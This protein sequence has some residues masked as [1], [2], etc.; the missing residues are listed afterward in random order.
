[1]RVPIG[2]Y[3]RKSSPL[4][5]SIQEYLLCSER[6]VQ[7]SCGDDAAVF[8]SVFLRRMASNIIRTFCLE[9]KGRECGLPEFK[10]YEFELA[11]GAACARHSLLLAGVAALSHHLARLAPA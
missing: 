9:Y 11:G 1:M 4:G 8:I 3:R 5:G 6:T 2:I 7:R 10:S